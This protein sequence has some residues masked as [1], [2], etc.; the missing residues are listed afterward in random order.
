MSRTILR[1]RKSTIVKSQPEMSS[2]NFSGLTQLNLTRNLFEPALYRPL[3]GLFDFL[4]GVP[5]AYA[6]G[7]MLATCSAGAA[8]W[9]TPKGRNPTLVSGR[10]LPREQRTVVQPDE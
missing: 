5:G 10:E 7:F 9:L 2:L 1:I 6:P 8:A 3:R 4:H